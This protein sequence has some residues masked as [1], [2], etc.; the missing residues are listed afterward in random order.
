MQQSAPL[1]FISAIATIFAE[2]GSSSYSENNQGYASF[3]ISMPIDATGYTLHGHNLQGGSIQFTDQGV[4]ISDELAYETGSFEMPISTDLKSNPLIKTTVHYNAVKLINPNGIQKLF[5]KIGRATRTQVV[6]GL[7]PFVLKDGSYTWSV[8]IFAFGRQ[9]QSENTQFMQVGTSDG[10]PSKHNGMY[11]QEF[12]LYTRAQGAQR[13]AAGHV[14][15]TDS[16][17]C[18][19]IKAAY[20]ANFTTCHADG[21]WG[22]G[23]SDPYRTITGACKGETIT[24]P[25]GPNLD[26]EYGTFTLPTVHTPWTATPSDS[27]LVGGKRRPG[28]V[29]ATI[30]TEFHFIAQKIRVPINAVLSL[31]AEF[32][33]AYRSITP[34][35]LRY[36]CKDN[37]YL[38]NLLPEESCLKKSYLP[39]GAEY[40]YFAVGYEFTAEDDT[41]YAVRYIYIPEQENGNRFAWLDASATQIYA[42][43]VSN[44]KTSRE[45]MKKQ[46]HAKLNAIRTMPDVYGILG[47][48]FF[49]EILKKNNF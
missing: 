3:D 30:E 1:I 38:K 43:S 22:A 5:I 35:N 27:C 7:D 37:A 41:R 39:G 6:S 46:L 42:I 20:M 45:E 34:K 2:D 26:Y 13:S 9:I 32:G 10:D 31:Y 33:T 16:S 19:G 8:P 40:P 21:I 47:E 12:Y 23:G 24:F 11:T 15:K 28:C 44:G 29:N 4:F 14:P 49:A 17:G 36:Q 48:H 18:F 25:A